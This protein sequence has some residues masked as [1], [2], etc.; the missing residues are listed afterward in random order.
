NYLGHS[1]IDHDQIYVYSDL[2]TGGF[3]S[4]N[5]LNDYNPTRGSSGWNETWIQNTCI[6]YNSSVPYN[7]ENCNTANLFVPYLASN[8]IFI[9]AGTQVAFICN[10]NGSSTRLNLKQWQA[11]GLDI[12]TTIDTTPTIQTIIEWGR[13]MLQNTI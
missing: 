6:L 7:I 12:G 4:N 13:K 11:Y 10:V 8:K 3:G 5:C 2:S 1:K 9:P